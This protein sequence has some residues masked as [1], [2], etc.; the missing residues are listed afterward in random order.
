MTS[1]HTRLDSWRRAAE[2]WVA[3]VALLALRVALAIPFFRSGLTK[4]E[5]PF[6]LSSGAKY[7]FTEEF[8]LHLGFA[9]IPY[10]APLL[11]AFLA[12]AGEIVLPILLVLGLATRFSALGIF[13]MT[14]IIQLTIPD[15]LINFHLPWAAMALALL[16]YGGG[17]F[18]ADA[19]LWRRVGMAPLKRDLPLSP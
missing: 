12:G 8:R 2:L 18:S 1:L 4:W 16:A 10:P 9:D 17:L 19:V 14:I 13:A 5:A 11:M 3:P 7:L 6:V 15:G